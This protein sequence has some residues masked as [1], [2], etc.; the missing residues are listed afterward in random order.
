MSLSTA[1]RKAVQASVKAGAEQVDVVLRPGEKE[2]LKRTAKE[3]AEEAAARAEAQAIPEALRTPE[4][5]VEPRVKVDAP[6]AEAP[7]PS[8]VTIEDLPPPRPV[9]Q[10][11]PRPF[12]SDPPDADAAARLSRAK[13]S[14]YSLD[15]VHQPNFDTITTTDEVKA[16]IAD[17]AQ[18]NV[19]RIDEARRG[20]ITNEQ[21][22][23]LANDLALDT[24]VV[25]RVMTRET[26]GILNAET[27]LASRQLLN[28]SATR[29]KDL[30]GK[31]TAGTANDLEKI[32]FARQFQFHAE[33]QTQFM[34]AR[35][36]AGRALNA[37]SIPAGAEAEQLRA[38]K[39]LIETTHGQGVEGLAKV[40]SQ[41]DTTEGLSSL[42]R[43]YNRARVSDVVVELFINSILSGP[44]THIIN[45]LGNT[46][47]GTMNAVE[48]VVA[49]RLG[50]FL[51]GEE[52]VLLGE[53]QAMLHGQVAATSDALR[54]AARAMRT[55]QTVDDVVKYGAGRQAITA[56]R[57][58]PPGWQ[59]TPIGSVVDV[60][61]KIIRL[62]TERVMA[63]TDEFFKTMAYRGEI[64]REAYIHAYNQV[65]AGAITPAQAE[66]VAR[67]FIENAPLK[68][69]KA[70]TQYMEYV[71]F[72][73]P[74][75]ETGRKFQQALR[76]VPI[77]GVIAPFIRTP[78]NIFKA[79]ILERSP[80]AVFSRKFRADVAAGGRARDLALT[81]VGM[82]T[83]TSLFIADRVMGGQ[84]TGG[85]PNEP[86]ARAL[87]L[88]SGWRPYSIRWED[89]ATGEVKYTSYARLE[90]LAFVV[91]AVAD[92]VEIGAYVAD[93]SETLKSEEDQL[94][95]TAAAIVAG[96]A[97]NTMSKTFMKGLAD[98]AE[99]LS[100][101]KRYFKRWEQSLGT[102]MVPFSALRRQIAAIQDPYLR[103]AWTTLD[104]LKADSGIPGYSASLPPKR[105]VFGE[106]RLRST[107]D[108]LGPMS[109]LPTSIAQDDTVT[110]ELLG[111][112]DRTRRVPVTM[113]SKLVDGL[114]LN[115]EEYSDLVR[116]ARN[117]PLSNGLTFKENLRDLMDT[118]VYLA[119]TPDM[120]V[121]L[122]KKLQSQADE[123]GRAVLLDSN[124]SFAERKA[125]FDLKR[126][127][128]LNDR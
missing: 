95:N 53:T 123:Y 19:G 97:N 2:L 75:G 14:D 10:S 15:E 74:L 65:A 44:K 81:R 6:A 72:Q 117:Q 84:V 111:L 4:A 50:R 69:Q 31:V 26:G 102:A 46:L 91:G 41:I 40:I 34:G 1:L 104:T 58:L 101:P 25:Q 23:G 77:L 8:S 32:Q 33:F 64:E 52:H 20:T 11:A 37:F 55:G 88:A 30:A 66:S 108:V 94:N 9:E 29:L 27:I 22:Q 105:D 110:T 85:G 18:R 54:L 121:E 90:P 36:E 47:F 116:F 86:S 61:G 28:S 35:A 98:F 73:N 60:L 3:T 99:M 70:A 112:M 107:S 109:P 5:A 118:D 17:T 79:G 62:P 68:A 114:K 82:G 100:D 24:E 87:L 80:L 83:A 92:A 48:T 122:I 7:P 59:G 12:V 103:E 63:P 120:Q 16:V 78:V 71:T 89:P 67:Q 113:P 38:M 56:A 49:A 126:D 125:R 13:L 127:R 93:D 115:A 106:P 45:T 124:P 21:L 42:A 43:N 119:A 76:S 39:D 128:L 51:S 57:L 96:I